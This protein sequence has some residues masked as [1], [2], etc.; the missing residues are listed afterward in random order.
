MWKPR[1]ETDIFL[2]RIFFFRETGRIAGRAVE[3]PRR[4]RCHPDSPSLE[5]KF[6]GGLDANQIAEVL[7]V[8]AKTVSR[9]WSF[10]KLWLLRQLSNAA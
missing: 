10:A 7:N 6:F 9:D 2:K 8:S 4:Q 5:L 1:P 3:Y